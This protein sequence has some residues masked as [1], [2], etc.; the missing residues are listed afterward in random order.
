MKPLSSAR[1]GILLVVIMLTP[2]SPESA[3]AQKESE[4]ATRQYAAAVR[5]QNLESYDL[6][7]E[8][9]E[10]FLL[11]FK[12]DPRVGKATHYLGVCYFQ[13][14]KLQQALMS[15]QKVVSDYPQLET[16]EGAYLYLGV[17][18]YT[19]AQA[20][21]RAMYESAAATFTTLLKKFPKDKF[22]PDALFYHAECLYMLDKKQ[23]AAKLYAQLI[24]D[25]PEHR[26]AADSLY[27]LGVAEEESGQFE[28]A[29]ATYD[30]F[31]SKYAE[32]S[33]A[34]EVRMRRGETLFAQQ[35]YPEAA[36]Q[37][38]VV[39]S[40]GSASSQDDLKLADYATVRQAD[41]LAQMK[42]YLEA[43]GLYATVPGK[44]PKSQHVG[45]AE[46]AAGKCYYLAGSYA[47]ARQMLDKL[48]GGPSAPEAAHWIAKSQLK[49]NR[50]AEALATVEKV[51]P[52]AKENPFAARLLMDQADAL[53]ELPDR[54]GESVA[55]YA[56]VASQYPSDPVAPQALYMAAFAA[57]QLGDYQAALKHSQAFRAAHRDNELVPDVTHLEAESQLLLGKLPEAE[58]LYAELLK[59]YPQHS[60]AELWKVRRA[61]ALQLQKQYDQVIAALEP[62]LGE[63]K[64]PD[65]AAEARYLVG[66]SQLEL[67][68]HREAAASLEASLEQQPKW[69]QAGET[70]LALARAYRGLNDYAKAQAALRQL[71]AEMPESP[72][73]DQAYYW[74]GESCSLAGDFDAAA[75]AYGELIGRWPKSPLLPHGMHELGC[76]EL[77]RKDAA[78]AEKAL[79]RMIQE[80]PEHELIPQSRYARAMARHQLQ[81]YAP[82]IEDLEVV[83]A[84]SPA[85][86]EK[87]D[88][89]Y[90]LGL[91]QMG[92]EKH[93]EAAGT[94]R[95]LL[96][97][98]PK[99][100]AADNARYQL[101]WAL[102][103]SGD[104]A[105]AAGEFEKLASDFP[106]SERAAEALYHVAEFAYASGDY[107]KAAGNYY[108]A[109]EK[110]GKSELSEK[111][112]HKL[113]WS[114][115]HQKNLEKAKQTFAYQQKSYPKGE[116][117]RDAAFMEGECLFEEKKFDEALAAYEKLPALD[118]PQ[119]QALALLHAGQ[120]AGQ[121]G[122]WQK[123][124]QSTAE[125][126]A[127][128]PES[129]YVAEALYEQG[130]AQQNLGQP[131]KALELYRQVIAKTD[132]DVAARAQFMIGEIQ[133]E[134]KEHSE[135]VKSFFKVV[136][137][138]GAAKWQADAAYEAG[139]CF[140]VLAKK[141][142]AVKMYQEL[143]E[144]FPESD[145]VPLAKKR[146][147]E[148]GT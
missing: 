51:L 114:Y 132:T 98:D 71:I 139:R 64:S 46:L 138:Y 42:Q 24:K 2:V 23:E 129:A 143:I 35:K 94:F 95:D 147:E 113:A 144:K 122:Q 11:D 87:S 28:A 57:L 90:V 103:L 135:A 66:S 1:L 15:F 79:D 130:W 44:F 106:E 100:A 17:T 49:E 99:Y 14:G 86:A 3:H 58:K 56:A 137:G 78:A 37:F 105:R 48:L 38:A 108:T 128:F 10:K 32:N 16:I 141:A 6:A 125:C 4:A 19:I 12:T 53:Y 54:R 82:A 80:F 146:I 84:G 121:L 55:K 43:A 140:E 41:A 67:K 96:K 26:F 61:F 39:A 45:R 109:L 5:L 104:E 134:K 142:Q 111:A 21:E 148:I 92:L 31:L 62:G 60:D 34:G 119:F 50:P 63:I 40:A 8:A 81:K 13:D 73:L 70:R 27:A 22:A 29:G 107:G 112:S 74:L 59:A 126:S 136:Y 116:L 72:L 47:A 65:L 145:K 85:Q 33:L 88:A 101:A 102:K 25:Y 9:W 123:A 93:G 75:K 30:S 124:L 110:A 18:Q 20:G 120:A 131:D 115:Y 118:N 91:C 7:A 52:P 127:K 77:S 97:E 133:F 89:R 117:A 69:R 76:T 36:K 68:Q 83:L